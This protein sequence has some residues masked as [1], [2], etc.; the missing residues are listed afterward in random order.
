[1]VVFFTGTSSLSAQNKTADGYFTSEALLAANDTGVIVSIKKYNPTQDE[2]SKAAKPPKNAPLNYLMAPFEATNITM[3]NK[4]FESKIYALDKKG[5]LLWERTIGYNNKSIPSPVKIAG[6]TIYA[7][8]GQK[9]RRAV[10]IQKIDQYGKVVWEKVLDSLDNVNDLFITK[11][12]V[13]ALVSFDVIKRNIQKNGTFS[14]TVY[15]AYFFIQLN[16]ETGELIKKEY[17]KMGS[18]LSGLGFNNPVLNTDYS[19]LI[20]KP[21]SAAFLTV[22]NLENATIVSKNPNMEYSILK[23]SADTGS[24]Q[25]LTL[26]PLKKGKNSYS[27]IYDNYA[28]GKKYETEVPID[29]SDADRQFITTTSVDSLAVVIGN[30][31]SISMGFIDTTGKFSLY[32]KTSANGLPVTAVAVVSGKIC[33]LQVEGRNKPGAIGKLKVDYY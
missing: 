28:R 14:E 31:Y 25:F 33:I 21:D 2:I 27:V 7:G 10:S 3:G 13:S 5:D 6:H 32:K 9:D 1:M 20:S 17:Q 11:D 18:Y 22:M 16:N 24:Y 23:L 30:P 12:R 29:H 26:K 8:E 19:Y 4:G 15:P